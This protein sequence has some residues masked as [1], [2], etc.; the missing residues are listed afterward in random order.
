[1]SISIIIVTYNS[2]D[3]IGKLLDSVLK[4]DYDLENLNII[5]VDNNSSDKNKLKELIKIYRKLIKINIIYKNNNKGFGSSCNL[6]AR[7]ASETIL[8]LNP[9]TLLHRSAITLM[10]KHMI[11]YGANIIGG[12][13]MKPGTSELHRTVFRKPRLRAMILEFCNIGKLTGIPSNFYVQQEVIR[14]DQYVDGVG[15]GFMMIDRNTFRTLNGFD[16]NY[17][18][19]LEDV[20]LCMRATAIGSKIMYCP[21]SVINH[22]GGASSNNKYK[23]SHAA[24][25]SS[26]EYYASKQFN[27]FVYVLLIVIYRFERLI[28]SAREAF[29]S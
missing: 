7:Y 2:S 5:I 24:W 13:S 3:H 28:L 6:G 22:V 4:Q 1:M 18:M 17:F 12:K 21:H 14:N 19:Y 20:D 29:I 8:F 27:T 9:D 16:E 11:S 25:Y 15:A 10:Y 23:I 26:R